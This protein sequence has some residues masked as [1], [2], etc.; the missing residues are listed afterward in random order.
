MKLQ[1]NR[2]SYLLIEKRFMDYR[3]VKDIVE[4]EG[5]DG[6]G[7]AMALLLHLC[8]SRDGIARLSSVRSLAYQ[9]RTGYLYTCHIIEDYRLFRLTEDGLTYYSPYL[10]K[11]ADVEGMGVAW[12]LDLSTS[13]GGRDN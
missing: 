7:M 13:E 9:L 2:K 4:E 3:I 10:H 1:A 6:L 11:T 12:I 8:Q 5:S